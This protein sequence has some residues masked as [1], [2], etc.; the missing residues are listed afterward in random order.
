M[1]NSIVNFING[2][3]RD[4]KGLLCDLH[5]I[6]FVNGMVITCIVFYGN[7]IYITYFYFYFYVFNFINKF[8]FIYYK[9]NHKINLTKF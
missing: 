4:K 6:M 3:W 2:Q 1:D 8:K 5:D 7:L 9:T